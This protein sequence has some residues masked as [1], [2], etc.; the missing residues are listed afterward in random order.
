V[1]SEALRYCLEAIRIGGGRLIVV[2]AVNEKA[3][4]WYESKGFTPIGASG[5]TGMRL[6][7]KASR[8]ERS[9]N[10]SQP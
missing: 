3:H 2:D 7:M 8:A 9:V 1:L 4:G 10:W 5:P 6:V